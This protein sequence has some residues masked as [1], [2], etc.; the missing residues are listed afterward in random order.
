MMWTCI[1][2][3]G[4]ALLGWSVGAKDSANVF[5][6]A[7]SSRMVRYR[8]AIVLTALFVIIGGITQGQAGIK[9]LSEGLKSKAETT[10]VSSSPEE[11]KNA[12]KIS[13]EKAVQ[14]AMITS[15]AAA[16]TITILTIMKIPAATAQAVIGA[17]I[18]VGIM[19]NNLNITGL[20]KIIICWIL[21][22]FG[23]VFFTIL[24]Y[25]IFRYILKKWNP[26]VLVYDPVITFLL[27]ICG[28]YGAYALGA[29][30]AANVAAVFVGAGM[31]TV[32]E[33]A[34]F[35]SIAIAAGVLTYS[36]PVMLTVG[37]G[38][39]KLTSFTAFICVLSHAVTI[40]IFA[41]IGVPVSSSQAIVGAILG[42]SIIKG[43]H[44]VNYKTLRHI[45]AGWLS[46]PVIAAVF[47]A[48]GY[49]IAN[50]Q[51]IGSVY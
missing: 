45:F 20:S 17:I 30:N 8:L 28:C 13:T 40:H 19:K 50:L 10:I 39:V 24:F 38:I 12:Q 27:I 16:L 3:F 22:P 23:A 7:V 6:T 44:T 42:V 48:I 29:N 37:Q 51:Y 21:T 36:K 5:G 41:I 33:A 35:G 49:F 18:G 4:G 11:Q 32:N 14:T 1:Q 46:T 9:T 34:I 25:W 43:A 47:A 2:Y 26:S 15:F 31:L